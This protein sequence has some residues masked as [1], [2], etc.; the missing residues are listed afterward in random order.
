MWICKSIGLAK[1]MSTV[2]SF[3]LCDPRGL[4]EFFRN[5]PPGGGLPWSPGSGFS[6]LRSDRTV[7]FS[8]PIPVPDVEQEDDFFY[9][10]PEEKVDDEIVKAVISYLSRSRSTCER[11]AK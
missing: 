3:R 4:S 7:G 9:C 5:S 11:K 10:S 1:R 6:A 2:V 8:A